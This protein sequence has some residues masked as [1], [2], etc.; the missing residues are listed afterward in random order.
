MALRVGQANCEGFQR[1]IYF[2][3]I[4]YRASEH[5]RSEARDHGKGVQSLLN[6]PQHYVLKYLLFS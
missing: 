1:T 6:E 2:P 3:K 5:Q 4:L